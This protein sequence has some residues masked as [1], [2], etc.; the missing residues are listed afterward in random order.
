MQRARERERERRQWAFILSTSTA[1][2][3][4]LITQGNGMPGEKKGRDG[5]G[6]ERREGA[7]WW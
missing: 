6:K 2:I 3:R 5:G 7:R 4:S 1:L